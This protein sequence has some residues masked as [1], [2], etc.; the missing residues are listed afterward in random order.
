MMAYNY[1]VVMDATHA[2]Q[3]PGGAGGH[4]G[5]NRYYAPLLARAAAAIGVQGFFMETHPNPE[6]AL[7][8]GPNMLSLDQL[9]QLLAVLNR[10]TQL[11]FS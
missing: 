9:E 2:V 6:A 7:C 3:K 10:L 1:P 5:G 4:S 11:E 8:D